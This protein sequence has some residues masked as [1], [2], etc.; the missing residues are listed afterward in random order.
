VPDQ[1][2]V[3]ERRALLRALTERWGLVSPKMTV[4]Q[5]DR[6]RAKRQ[7]L[8]EGAP[9]WRRQRSDDVGMV[10]AAG[11]SAPP[12]DDGVL[13]GIDPVDEVG[14]E[15]KPPGALLVSW[16]VRGRPSPPTREIPS[17]VA[18]KTSSPSA[19]NPDRAVVART[20]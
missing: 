6:L 20:S 10:V 9:A 5:K 19:A 2:R 7:R 4:V 11:G 3:S 16:K 1:R 18:R 15:G 14:V 12:A 8:P 17:R 13:L